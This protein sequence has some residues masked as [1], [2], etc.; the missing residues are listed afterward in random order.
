MV[1]CRPVSS[2]TVTGNA[3]GAAAGEAVGTR[4][5]V[6]AVVGAAVTVTDAAAAADGVADAGTDRGGGADAQDGSTAR[7]TSRSEITARIGG[8]RGSGMGPRTREE[9]K[10]KTSCLLRSTRG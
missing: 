1:T 7:R 2:T 10:E 3:V 8:L 4:V 6:T 9:E 5:G